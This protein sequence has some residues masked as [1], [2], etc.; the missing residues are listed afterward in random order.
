MRA[1]T[2]PHV[3]HE[4]ETELSEETPVFIRRY[5]FPVSVTV[6][7][8]TTTIAFATGVAGG[9]VLAATI[10]ASGD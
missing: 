8:V 2:A 10:Q 5:G 3:I 6:A 4:A 9:V 1:E 7:F